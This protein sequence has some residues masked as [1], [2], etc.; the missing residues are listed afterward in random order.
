MTDTYRIAIVG[1]ASLSGKEMN[2]ALG[3]SIFAAA[4]FVLLDDDATLGQLESVG[5]E[6]TFIQRLEPSS[7]QQA[8]FTFF[9]GSR[10][11]TRK[12]CKAAQRAGSSILDL[13]GAL[14]SEPKVLVRAPWVREEMNGSASTESPDLHT[15]AVIPAHPASLT[16]ALLMLRLKNLA[17]IRNASV[18]ILEPA[19]EYGRPAMDELHQQ[20]VSLLSFQ[21]LPREIYDTQVAFNCVPVLGEAAKISLAESEATIRR[22]YALLSAGRLPQM[23]MQLIHSPVF[24]GHT[25]SIAVELE[26]A[27]SLEQLETALSGD[28]VDVVLGDA[29]APS[30]LSA[31]GQE[32]IM[33]RLRSDEGQHTQRFWIWAAVDNLKLAAVNA[34]ACALELRRLRPQGQV[35]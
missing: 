22:H 3:E 30:N 19:S 7:F 6:V 17:A 35:Q 15:P 32:D 25:F 27:V 5:D 1:A 14:E 31:A 11:L 16:L 2:E 34:V 9:C 24:H 28:H 29:D 21:T 10:E 23:A 8:D 33:V 18:T 13:S 20:T 26:Q 4:D 12:H